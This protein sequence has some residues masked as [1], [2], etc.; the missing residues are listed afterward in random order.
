M[1]E[2][3]EATNLIQKGN[4]TY[5]KTAVSQEEVDVGYLPKRLI[6][7]NCVHVQQTKKNMTIHKVQVI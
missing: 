3:T 4:V 6:C 1:K 2:R 7:N 5:N